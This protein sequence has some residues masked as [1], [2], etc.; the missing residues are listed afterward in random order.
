MLIILSTSLSLHSGN[1]LV[2]LLNFLVDFIDFRHV[3]RSHAE[4][5]DVGFLRVASIGFLV[6]DNIFDIIIDPDIFLWSLRL[7]L[8]LSSD[9]LLG[10]LRFFESFSLLGL[11]CSFLDQDFLDFLEDLGFRENLHGNLSSHWSL[12]SSWHRHG[13]WCFNRHL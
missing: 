13:V 8:G 10:S 1:L 12:L 5:D 11:N 3:D 2:V 4:W 9:L 7:R 6:S